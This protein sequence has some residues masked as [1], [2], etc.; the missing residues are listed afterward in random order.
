M[1]NLLIVGYHG[2]GNCGDDATLLA[3]VSNIRNMADDVHITAL[4]F[5]PEFTQTQYN[6]DAVQRL[7]ISAVI[8]T[9][10]NC[11]I[12]LLGGGSLLQDSTSTR[13]LV[14]YL[15]IITM[16]K[17]FKKR[18]MLYANGFGPV[19][20]KVNQ[21][22]TKKVAN[23][24]DIITLREKRSKD[25]MRKLGI[26][27][28]PMYVT[29]DAAFT[30]KAIEKKAAKGLLDVENIPYNNDIIGVSIRHWNRSIDVDSYVIAVAKACDKFAEDKKIILLIPMQFPEDVEISKKVM[31]KM[32]QK[33]YILS[34]GYS[35][36]EISGIISCCSV[37]LSMRLHALLFAAVERV[38]MIGIIYD[39][40]VANYL[41][42]LNMPDVGNV[43]N[44]YIE[45]SVIINKIED[46]LKNVDFYKSVLNE[47][48]SVLIENANQNNVLLEEQLELI[49]KDKR[50]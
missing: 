49:R 30:L 44:Q 19:Y 8:K 13:S 26:V 35:P 22:L 45:V 5:A 46:V 32:K 36:A 31:L 40:K 37:I 10:K 6:I 25:D 9:I 39:P 16:A 38:P 17:F 24:I 7:N 1:V 28:P 12:V 23:N 14:Y 11:D 34:K 20:R 2:F 41:E 15:G 18:V 43:E 42:V 3:M 50:G 21:R 47:K 33:S 4:S 27:K 29:A 48:V